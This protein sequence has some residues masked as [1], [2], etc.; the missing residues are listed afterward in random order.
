[1]YI[2]VIWDS[3]VQKTNKLTRKHTENYH[4]FLKMIHI[5]YITELISLMKTNKLVPN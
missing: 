2:L 4:K 3:S 5:M 1:M